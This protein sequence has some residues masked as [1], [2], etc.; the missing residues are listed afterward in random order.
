MKK[1]HLSEEDIQ[2]RFK[3]KTASVEDKY[4]Q[5][6]LINDHDMALSVHKRQIG[7]L[8]IKTKIVGIYNISIYLTL[9]C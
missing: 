2:D 8:K 9:G 4:L 1:L 3:W 6:F 7:M 5:G